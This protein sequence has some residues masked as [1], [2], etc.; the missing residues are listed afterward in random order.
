MHRVK[1][2]QDLRFKDEAICCMITRFPSLL[3]YNSETVLKPKLEFLSKS[4]GRRVYE[5]VEYPRYFSYSLEKKIKPRA[6]VIQR[7]KVNCSL[8]EMLALNDEQFAA[9]YLGVGGMLVPPR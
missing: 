2:L 9:K 4:M 7:R 1:Y 6:Q 8:K 3:S 5:V